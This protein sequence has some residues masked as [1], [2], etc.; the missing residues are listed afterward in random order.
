MSDVALRMRL[1]DMKAELEE[2]ELL[3]FELSVRDKLKDSGNLTLIAAIGFVGVAG[4][5]RF[6]LGQAG[7]G[8]LYL[9]TFGFCGIGTIIDMVNMKTTVNQLNLQTEYEELQLLVSAKAARER[10]AA[11][12]APSGSPV[13]APSQQEVDTDTTP[14]AGHE[15]VAEGD[16]GAP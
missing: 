9:L 14:T 15:D 5:H 6:I 16:P 11:K 7:M 2:D 4:I 8:I 12:Q 1:D 13:S 10:R 3:R